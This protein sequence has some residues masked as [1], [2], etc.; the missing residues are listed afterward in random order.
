MVRDLTRL[1]AVATDTESDIIQRVARR[2]SVVW[3]C[4]RCGA[5]CFDTTQ[6]CVECDLPR[7]S[8]PFT[9]TLSVV[10]YAQ[11][12]EEAFNTLRA[13]IVG[14]EDTGDRDNIDFKSIRTS[15]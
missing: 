11:S 8:V 12:K 15:A 1:L 14:T 3:A 10:V 7:D 4:P 13:S 2:A 9:V 6:A 5:H